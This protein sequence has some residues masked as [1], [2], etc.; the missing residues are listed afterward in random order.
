MIDLE[1]ASDGDFVYANIPCQ[2]SPV[3]AQIKNILYIE[4]A[5]ELWTD[6]W[7][8]RIVIT[9]NAYWDEKEA[10]R[11]KI[12]E[13]K[14]NYKDWIKEMRDHEETETDNRIDT[15]HNGVPGK[16]KAQRKT[17]GTKS[18]SKRI[19]RKQ[20]VIRKSPTQRRKS[21]KN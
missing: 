9:N 13:I 20:K 18:V 1:D 4:N 16:R 21:K 14:Y 15:I 2:A 6:T 19:K 8:R 10:K 5:I 12:V 17:A 7:G 3:F 11:N